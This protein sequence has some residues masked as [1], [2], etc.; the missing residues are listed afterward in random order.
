MGAIV[1][2]DAVSDDHIRAAVGVDALGKI[3]ERKGIFQHMSAGDTFAAQ[4]KAI[5][6]AGVIIAF[7]ITVGIGDTIANG[8][9]TNG[10]GFHLGIQVPAVV[11]VVIGHAA[12]EHIA[13]AA[14]QL[15]GK[16]VGILE[17]GVHIVVA[18]AIEDQIVGRPIF[19][20]ILAGQ[21]ADLNTGVSV[22]IGM[23]LV[24]NIIAAGNLEALLAVLGVGHIEAEEIPVVAAVNNAGA[25]LLEVQNRAGSRFRIGDH[26][27]HL[28]LGTIHTALDPQGRCHL[29]GAFH[30]ND[31]LTGHHVI[32]SGLN[33]IGI[34]P[35]AVAIGKACGRNINHRAVVIALVVD[36]GDLRALG[37]GSAQHGI[38][39]Q[40]L[41]RI[42]R[43]LHL[44]AMLAVA[45]QG[46]GLAETDLALDHIRLGDHGI[47]V[48]DLYG[49]V[50]IGIQEQGVL[51]LG[52]NRTGG[53]GNG[54]RDLGHRLLFRGSILCAEDG[55]KFHLR[56][57]SFRVAGSEEAHIDIVRVQ[58]IQRVSAVILVP[59]QDVTVFII[60]SN[61]VAG[62]VFLNFQNEGGQRYI[63]HRRAGFI[64]AVANDIIGAF[65]QLPFTRGPFQGMHL[66]KELGHSIGIVLLDQRQIGRGQ[67]GLGDGAQAQL[68]GI[69]G[70]GTV[71]IVNAA[72]FIAVFDLGGAGH[73][74][75]V[76]EGRAV[77]VDTQS[78]G[79][80]QA[81][82][83]L[84]VG[85]CPGIYSD[86]GAKGEIIVG[87]NSGIVECHAVSGGS[88]LALTVF[89]KNG[90]ITVFV[91]IA[92]V[93][94]VIR[95]GGFAVGDKAPGAL[96]LLRGNGAQSAGL[97]P[98]GATDGYHPEAVLLTHNQTAD[99]IFRCGGGTYG[100]VVAEDLIALSFQNRDPRYS[101]LAAAGAGGAEHGGAFE[102]Q[103]ERGSYGLLGSL[104]L[105]PFPLQNS[106]E[107]VIA[108]AFRNE[109]DGMAVPLH[110]GITG[111]D[112][113][114]LAIEHG[115]FHFVAAV[116]AHIGADGNSNFAVAGVH[117]SGDHRLGHRGP[118]RPVR[119]GGAG[120]FL[121]NLNFIMVI[122][123]TYIADV[124]GAGSING[125]LGN[126]QIVLFQLIGSL[127]DNGA[128]FQINADLS[129]H[130]AAAPPYLHG[131]R[132]G[133]LDLNGVANGIFHFGSGAIVQPLRG[134]EPVAEA[135]DIVLHLGAGAEK[136]GKITVRAGFYGVAV[137]LCI[138]TE[139]FQLPNIQHI[140][141][142]FRPGRQ[143]QHGKQQTQCQHYGQKFAKMLRFHMTPPY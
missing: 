74:L 103:S 22:T 34:F 56:E 128:V 123:A 2:A 113:L 11:G 90:N 98:L 121:G 12:I 3:E 135:L 114:A 61:E 47:A 54:G 45:F 80:Q 1:V 67:A 84:A 143:R 92:R 110:N 58:L 136:N 99:C 120:V 75:I 36:H 35:G 102:R 13:L 125:Q 25:S 97:H 48:G 100:N 79:C 124:V 49:A 8:N 117:S 31:G 73:E 141:G 26:G 19:K 91:Q 32:H 70:A 43:K 40:V 17:A 50:H 4:L 95:A 44:D 71:D 105:L 130:I 131:S 28:F 104:I 94:I 132:A 142:A 5:A 122:I 64:G 14:G 46:K 68:H 140:G 9:G 39:A 42:R 23:D 15:G 69:L 88:D 139:A 77:A 62:V 134:V 59:A 24:Q 16:A 63:A 7:N 65:V 109:S 129:V 118:G 33:V 126:A 82:A 21:T 37:L 127:G 41:I 30:Q 55:G 52:G 87:G 51:I 29:V 101:N 60:I 53:D 115:H 27:N 107:D 72:T 106:L 108:G 133:S 78:V 38:L 10:T 111:N 89:R 119:L 86:L 57:G 66:V 116:I 83:F 138:L 76:P 20:E 18:V 93:T 137:G 6:V 112:R 85:I 81:E 96:R